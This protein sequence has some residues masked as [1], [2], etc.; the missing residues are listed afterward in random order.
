MGTKETICYDEATFVIDGKECVG[1]S[2]I[3]IS[4]SDYIKARM[5]NGSL[6]KN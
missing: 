2:C 5:K 1:M 6:A 3:G 4:I